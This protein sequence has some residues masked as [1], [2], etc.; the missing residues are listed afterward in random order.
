M[1]SGKGF[2]GIAVESEVVA[3][4]LANPGSSAGGMLQHHSTFPKI[5]TIP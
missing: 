3:D 1:M 2:M 4:S 5:T